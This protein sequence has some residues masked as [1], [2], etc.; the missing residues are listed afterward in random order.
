LDCEVFFNLFLPGRKMKPQLPV[1]IVALLPPGIVEHIYK[2]V[3]H[4][5]VRKDR[6]PYGFTMSPKAET[7]LRMIQMS[8]LKGKCGMYL[9]DLEDFILER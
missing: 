3:P 5:K 1:E 9:R 6:S 7:E 8:T 4:L 2:Y